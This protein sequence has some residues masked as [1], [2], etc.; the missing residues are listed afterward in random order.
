MN[1]VSLNEGKAIVDKFAR[2]NNLINDILRS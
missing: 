2:V 1:P